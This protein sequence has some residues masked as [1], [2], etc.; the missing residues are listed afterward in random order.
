MTSRFM[1]KVTRKMPSITQVLGVSK[2]V[3]QKAG[4]IKQGLK[5]VGQVAKLV[6]SG[7]EK[8]LHNAKSI[9]TK[10]ISKL[11]SSNGNSSTAATLGKAISTGMAVYSAGKNISAML[12]K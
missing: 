7:P 4:N 9:I 12:K 6:G 8:F 10:P 11:G 3:A 5:R 1:T 2:R